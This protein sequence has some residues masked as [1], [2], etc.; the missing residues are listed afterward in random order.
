MTTAEIISILLKRK[1][2]A[3]EQGWESIDDDSQY[4]ISAGYIDAI[5]E[6][7]SLLLSEKPV[8][9]EQFAVLDDN[10]HHAL[11]MNT[12]ESP[13]KFIVAYQVDYENE[14][15][16]RGNYFKSIDMAIKAFRS[17]QPL[18]EDARK[19]LTEDLE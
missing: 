12:K 13:T 1:S 4:Y 5:D 7:V 3:E 6:T 11:L 2:D 9:K 19:A 15:W 16:A 10:G 17:S 8:L 18:P 14:C